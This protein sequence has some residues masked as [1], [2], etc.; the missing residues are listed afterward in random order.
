MNRVVVEEGFFG[1][2]VVR[3]TF[4]RPFKV[5]GHVTNSDKSQFFLIGQV[6]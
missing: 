6:E 5:A 4:N 1:D 2:S 3:E